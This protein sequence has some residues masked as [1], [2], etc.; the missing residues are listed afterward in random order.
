[1]QFEIPSIGVNITVK[2]IFN[3]GLANYAQ[4][5]TPIMLPRISN[6]VSYQVF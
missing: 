2:Y 5:H 1:M 4:A 6:P 3:T